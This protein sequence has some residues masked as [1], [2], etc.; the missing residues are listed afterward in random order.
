LYV[1]YLLGGV[2]LG[3]VPFDR[4][5]TRTA[6]A[7]VVFALSAIILV[8]IGASEVPRHYRVCVLSSVAEYGFS[9]TLSLLRGVILGFL[10]TLVF[11]GELVGRKRT[12][13]DA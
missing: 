11:S 3:A 7:R 1:I 6:W 8:F 10:L 13:E 2:V 4:K 9:H 12:P 5:K